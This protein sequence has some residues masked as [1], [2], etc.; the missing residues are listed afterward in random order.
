M[1]NELKANT[2]FDWIEPKSVHWPTKQQQ[3]INLSEPLEGIWPP[4]KTQDHF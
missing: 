2:T 1:I 3:P 4:D